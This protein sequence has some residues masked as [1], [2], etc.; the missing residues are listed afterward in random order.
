[1][2]LHSRIAPWALAVVGA[3][4]AAASAT[5]LAD[6]ARIV[7]WSAWTAWLLP[8]SLDGLAVCAWGAWLSRRQV[9]AA[10]CG[11]LAVAAS[12]GGNVAAHVYQRGLATPGMTA[13]ALVA[14]VPPVAFT[15]SMFFIPPRHH[16]TAAT[17]VT[18]A[19]GGGRHA[20]A[21]RA[22]TRAATSDVT[23]TRAVSPQVR[24]VTAS[25]TPRVTPRAEGSR[26]PAAPRATVTAATPHVT[27]PTPRVT[28]TTPRPTITP[29]A[30]VTPDLAMS[31]EA[32]AAWCR[33]HGATAVAPIRKLGVPDK[34]ARRI[35]PLAKVV[36]V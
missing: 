33:R 14:A 9:F 17:A 31:D 20:K 36:Q 11:A 5:A 19:A 15:L 6:L 10:V 4:T 29:H 32:L 23:P 8:L 25:A 2:D 30:T 22:A 18:V 16:A 1:M 13:V 28:P 27:A 35:A 26:D 3:A 24:G 21:A 12:A 7:G 34:R